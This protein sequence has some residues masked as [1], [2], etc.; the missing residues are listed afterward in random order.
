SYAVRLPRALHSFPT[1]RSSDLSVSDASIINIS[2]MYGMVS[3]DLRIYKNKLHAN[4][5]FYGTAKAALLQLTKYAACEYGPEGI[6]VNCRS[7][8]HTSELQS[9][10]NLVCRLLL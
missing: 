6:R 5:P 1:R 4:P 3:P 7:E 10:E 2:S 8:E 9:R